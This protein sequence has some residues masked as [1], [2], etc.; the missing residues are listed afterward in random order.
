MVGDFGV[1]LDRLPEVDGRLVAFLGS[2]IGNLTVEERA[3]FL[4]D[5]AARLRPGEGLLLGLDLVKDP[6]R[7]VAAYDDAAGVTAA[8][9]KNVL[10]VIN[11]SLVADFDLDSFD[12]MARWDSQAEHITM[13]LRSRQAQ[14][15]AVTGL[16]ITV[17]L[18]A[19]EE[20]GTETSAKFRRDGITTELEAAGFVPMGWWTDSCGDFAVA[21]AQRSAAGPRLAKVAAR[22][23][24]SGGPVPPRPRHRGLPGRAGGHRSPC[25]PAVAG[26]S[27]G[28]D[29][30]RRQPHQM[31]PG[32]RHL[33]LRAVRADSLPTG[34]PPGGRALPLPVELLLRRGRRAA[35]PC[36]AG[37]LEPA[38]GRR[39]D[40]LPRHHRRSHGGPARPVVA[41]GGPRPG[42]AGPAPR[43]AAPGAAPHGH[44]ARPGHATRCGPPTD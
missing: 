30:A 8:F 38:R 21:L 3:R 36:R 34:L 18:A 42:R 31:A 2:T 29:H 22:E 4:A 9:E 6:A 28:A 24:P 13:G 7:L 39:G 44:Q 32:P 26:R 12:Y 1:H 35:S 43:A 27:D 14:T 15:V 20:I 5:L 41:R 37:P 19:G 10:A 23:I 17:D 33:V 11:A 16:G 40:R 25:R